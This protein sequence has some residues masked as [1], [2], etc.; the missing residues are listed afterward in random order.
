LVYFRLSGCLQAYGKRPCHKQDIGT[1]TNNPGYLVFEFGCSRKE[2]TEESRKLHNKKRDNLYALPTAIRVI[3]SS[4]EM[5]G[6]CGMYGGEE[7]HT[8]YTGET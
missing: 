4:R 3:K 8:D 2:V 5:G 1:N 7:M 6:T